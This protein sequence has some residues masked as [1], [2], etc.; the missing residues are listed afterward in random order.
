MNFKM[1]VKEYVD[2]LKNN[3]LDINFNDEVLIDEIVKMLKFDLK[4]LRKGKIIKLFETLKDNQILPEIKIT[5]SKK[6]K[7]RAFMRDDFSLI[8]STSFLAKDNTAKFI[9][10][11]THEIAHLHLAQ[12][13][14]YK[15]LLKL[16]EAFLTK[17]GESNDFILISPVEH[18][19]DVLCFNLL[20][21]ISKKLKV[22]TANL[23]NQGMR[24]K[25]RYLDFFITENLQ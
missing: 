8:L 24:T 4:F 21:E 20:K 15:D 25:Q 6:S 2:I 14:N 22:K 13:P 5:F 3:K 23:L 19:A 7:L 1:S 17:Y 12:Q 10:T 18:F 11:L 9:M 16:D